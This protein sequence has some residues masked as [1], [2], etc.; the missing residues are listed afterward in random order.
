[1][2]LCSISP[3]LYVKNKVSSVFIER[4]FD[5]QEVGI[6]S[7]GYKIAMLVSVVSGAFYKAYN[8][9]K[10]HGVH[11]VYE[12]HTVCEVY[13]VHNGVQK[14]RAHKANTCFEFVITGGH[15]GAG[16]TEAPRE[17]GSGQ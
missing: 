17:A 7:L 16:G 6:Y 12:D 13:K 9:Y 15:G 5:A 14:V 2:H 11:K 10:G 1:M 3:L 4:Y 8:P